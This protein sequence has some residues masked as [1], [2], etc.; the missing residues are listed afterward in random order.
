MKVLQEEHPTLLSFRKAIA[1]HLSSI[2]Q[3]PSE[4]LLPLVQQNTGHHR[5]TSHSLFYVVIKRLG[6]T[7]RTGEERDL[8]EDTR[9]KCLHLSSETQGY[10]A[11]VRTTKDMLLFDPV[12]LRLI[13]LTIKSIVDKNVGIDP[14]RTLTTM[15]GSEGVVAVT[16][17][18][19]KQPGKRS[20]SADQIV[21][22]NGS[23]IQLDENAYCALRRTVLT[24]FIARTLGA[25]YEGRIK[26]IMGHSRD[27]MQSNIIGLCRGLDLVDSSESLSASDYERCMT[28]VKRV[29]QDNK[30]IQMYIKDDACYVDLTCRQ[31]GK[32]KVFSSVSADG[33][34]MDGPTLIVQ[35]MMSFVYH[36]SVYEECDRYIWLVPDSR[37][38]FAEQVLYL[39]RII[40]SDDAT[41]NKEEGQERKE[42]SEN[43]RKSRKTRPWAESIEVVYFGAATGPDIWSTNSELSRG[44][45]GVVEY[46][47]QRM[48]AVVSRNRGNP[49]RGTDYGGGGGGGG[50]GGDIG[51]GMDDEGDEEPVLDEVELSRM[52]TLLSMSALAV[53]CVGCKRIRKLTVDTTRVLEGKGNSGVFL[54]YVHSRLCGIERKSKTRLNPEA[55]LSLVQLYPEA[56]NLCIVLAEWHDT[57]GMIDE[58]MDPYMLVPYLFHLATEI[59]QANHVLRVKDMERAVAEA[60][61]LLFWAAKQVLEQGLRLLGIEFVERM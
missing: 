8:D 6:N 33:S 51:N 50:G 61:W 2:L 20:R 56:L 9:Q 25:S 30:G 3:K 22:V 19:V 60:R 27:G 12:P 43:K 23:T 58:S 46:T 16:S 52:A 24:G 54:Q 11:R 39:A 31:L 18:S 41:D 59:G 36:F 26:V 44:L 38:Q 40:F 35:T 55:D 57:L 53:A 34:F 1:S 17:K 14:E 10:I 48:K 7:A 49:G 29:V 42:V 4:A 47:N 32:S 45:T 5:K 37:R 15:G 28:A 13:Q 21:I